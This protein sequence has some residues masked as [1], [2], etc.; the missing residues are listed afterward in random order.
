MILYIVN[1]DGEDFVIETIRIEFPVNASAGAISCVD[2]TVIDDSTFEDQ[3]MVVYG[4]TN[5]TGTGV[6]FDS[7][8][9]GIYTTVFIANNDSKCSCITSKFSSVVDT[10][11]HPECVTRTS[12]YISILIQ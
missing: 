12:D 5:V 2:F 3:E 11:S 7:A 1:T 10:N 8:N 6:T 9:S 4:I